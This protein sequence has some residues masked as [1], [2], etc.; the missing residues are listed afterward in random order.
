MTVSQ[1]LS[2]G[3]S[4][5]GDEFFAEVTNE[6]LGEKGVSS[7]WEQLPMARLETLVK[8]KR[9]GRDGW[10]VSSLITLLRLTEEK[11]Q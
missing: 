8:Q 3:I 11:F 5:E 4:E 2:A 9:L 6:V 1:V 7:L 10:I